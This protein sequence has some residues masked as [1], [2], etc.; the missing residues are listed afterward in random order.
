MERASLWGKP[1]VGCGGVHAGGRSSRR[2]KDI[3]VCG[4]S[5]PG[6]SEPE[7]RRGRPTA[8]HRCGRWVAW[9]EESELEQ[10]EEDIHNV[11]G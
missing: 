3:R 10:G 4:V 1:G 6:V 2:V 11:R 7:K 9:P 5:R 8:G